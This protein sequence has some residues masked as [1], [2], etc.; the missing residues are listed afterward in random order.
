MGDSTAPNDDTVPPYGWCPVHCDYHHCEHARPAMTKEH[1][2]AAARDA[3]LGVGH[4]WTT[5]SCPAYRTYNP[6]DCT[7]RN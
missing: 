1:W 7:C 5:V 6:K 4:I 3:T 2:D